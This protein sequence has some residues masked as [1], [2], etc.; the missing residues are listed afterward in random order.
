[1]IKPV[2]LE[3]P[4]SGLTV[5]RRP[6]PPSWR[7]GSPAEL[8]ALNTQPEG[9]RGWVAMTG[10]TR[11]FAHTQR[12]PIAGDLDPTPLWCVVCWENPGHPI[13]MGANG[14]SVPIT[15]LGTRIRAR[16]HPDHPARP[17]TPHACTLPLQG[18]RRQFE[19]RRVEPR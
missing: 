14:G 18:R 17:G 6:T 3:L 8:T 13:T 19:P 1:M 2:A 9:H 11:P 12:P 7:L 15:P 16:R 10:G 5:Q 4:L